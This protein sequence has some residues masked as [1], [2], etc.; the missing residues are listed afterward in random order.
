MFVLSCGPKSG[1]KN[2]ARI[3]YINRFELNQRF[4]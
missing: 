2:V 3:I 1:K 4:F